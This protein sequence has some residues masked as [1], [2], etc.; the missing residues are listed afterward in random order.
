MSNQ[1]TEIT[2]HDSEIR[3]AW[4]PEV[5]E[6]HDRSLEARESADRLAEISRDTSTPEGER[7]WEAS[8]EADALGEEFSDKQTEWLC[9]MPEPSREKTPNL[10]GT[11]NYYQRAQEQEREDR[12]REREQDEISAFHLSGYADREAG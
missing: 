12:A 8:W 9:T 1:Q 6:A 4:P 7:A 10:W 3:A 2:N 5:R 11:W